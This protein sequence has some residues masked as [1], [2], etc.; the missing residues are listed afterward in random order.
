M[1]TRFLKE[2]YFLFVLIVSMRGSLLYNSKEMVIFRICLAAFLLLIFNIKLNKSFVLIIGIWTLFVVGSA[3]LIGRFVPSILLG[4]SMYFIEAYVI[5]RLFGTSFFNVFIKWMVLLAFISIIGW[6]LTLFFGRELYELVKPLNISGG[7]RYWLDDYAHIIFFTVRPE[8]SMR[9]MG[10]PRN[11]GFTWEPGPFSIILNLALYTNWSLLKRRK[12]SLNSII[13]LFA[14]VT[15]F[16]TTGYITLFAYLVYELLIKSK[17]IIYILP[18]FALVYGGF[19]IFREYEFLGDKVESYSTREAYVQVDIAG[20]EKYSGSRLS[21]LPLVLQDL[22]KNP[23]MGKALSQEGEY[24]GIGEIASSHLNTLFTITSSMGLFGLFWWL[25]FLIKAS[26]KIDN[27]F[28][29]DA[30]YTLIIII[31]L[32]SFGFNLHIWSIVW[33]YVLFGVFFK[34]ELPKIG[35]SAIGSETSIDFDNQQEKIPHLVKA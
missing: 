10:F 6:F 17:R 2:F 18:L 9:E 30:N 23:I 28:K 11:P 7:F 15:T 13:L 5:I 21:G 25:F 4:Y 24:K 8:A 22:A 34:N 32:S 31:M 1:I 16:S 12:N 3:G 29:P 27:I 19:H 20:N 14:L 35:Y 26:K 33:V